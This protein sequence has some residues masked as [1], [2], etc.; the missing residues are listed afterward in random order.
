MSDDKYLVNKIY[1]RRQ[2]YNLKINDE[3]SIHE[4][5]NEFNTLLNDLLEIDVKA[6]E[7]EHAI[8]L[9]CSIPKF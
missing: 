2:L 6:K 5:M 9:L 8:L 4:H 3:T 1:S 7:D